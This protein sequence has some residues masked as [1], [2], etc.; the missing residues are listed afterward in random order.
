M[1]VLT[2]LQVVAGLGFCLRVLQFLWMNERAAITLERL[3]LSLRR[4]VTRSEDRLA[5]L[6]VMRL[7]VLGGTSF[8]GRVAQ[9]LMGQDDLG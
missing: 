1:E 7:M 8:R 4:L 2:E 9:F 3:W 6:A 5:G